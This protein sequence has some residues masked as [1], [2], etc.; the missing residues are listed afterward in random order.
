[1]KSSFRSALCLL[2]L[3]F[4]LSYDISTNCDTDFT[5]IDGIG[6]YLLDSQELMTWDEAVNFCAQRNSRL[7]LRF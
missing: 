1:M 6:C 4:G 3:P 2:L 5:Y 7:V